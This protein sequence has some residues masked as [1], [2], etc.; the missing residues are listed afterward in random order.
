VE[1]S[2]NNGGKG[3]KDK[4]KR[5]CYLFEGYFIGSLLN[6]SLIFSANC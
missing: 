1:M 3:E 2:M 6:R 5:D 4:K